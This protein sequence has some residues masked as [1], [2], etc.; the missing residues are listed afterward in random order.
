MRE[1]GGFLAIGPLEHRAHVMDMTKPGVLEQTGCLGAASPAAAVHDDRP[2]S[3]SDF[4]EASR[5]LLKRYVHRSGN[6][7]VAE[8]LGR[9]NVE[10]DRAA[11]DEL[12]RGA[13]GR[14]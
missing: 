8:L 4:V 11:C 13:A 10:Q 9:A 3:R 12:A 2:V 7:L 6:V 14:E 5:E 1:S